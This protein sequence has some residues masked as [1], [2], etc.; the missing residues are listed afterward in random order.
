MPLLHTRDDNS[1]CIMAI[2]TDNIPDLHRKREARTFS[3]GWIGNGKWSC[4][5]HHHDTVFTLPLH[6][7]VQIIGKLSKK[8]L[9]NEYYLS[10]FHFQIIII[11]SVVCIWKLDVTEKNENWT[12]PEHRKEHNSRPND[13]RKSCGCCANFMCFCTIL[14]SDNDACLRSPNYSIVHAASLFCRV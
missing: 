2:P 8:E 10:F 7:N 11:M 14:G 12:K 5:S 3:G 1:I 9:R 13:G 6:C 4:Y